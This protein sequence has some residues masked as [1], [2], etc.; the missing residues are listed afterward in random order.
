MVNWG[1]YIY[2]SYSPR[3]A[4]RIRRTGTRNCIH[5]KRRKHIKRFSVGLHGRKSRVRLDYLL[6][7]TLQIGQND[8]K[9]NVLWGPFVV[10]LRRIPEYQAMLS[11][12]VGVLYKVKL[13]LFV[14]VISAR[15]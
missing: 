1:T 13:A 14:K 9:W 4:I 6:K 7:W 8:V 15:L 10:L 3:T 12:L 5:G 2:C 11:E